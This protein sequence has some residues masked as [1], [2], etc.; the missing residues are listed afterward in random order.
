MP[1]EA[2]PIQSPQYIC[3]LQT[4][5]TTPTKEKDKSFKTRVKHT[6]TWEANKIVQKLQITVLVEDS[7]AKKNSGLKAQHGLS[8]FIQATSRKT[9]TS[10]LMDTGPSGEAL[11]N[12]VERLSV[13]LEET[14]AILLSH[15]HYDHV[16]GLIHALKRI[17]KRVPIIA[18]PNVFSVKLKTK[19]K[20]RLIG[21]SFPTSE[22]EAYSTLVYAVN[23]VT[24]AEEIVASGEIPRRTPYE[25]VEGFWTVTDN[26]FEKDLILDDQALYVK[27]E[28]KGLVVITGCAHSGIINTVKHA[29]KIMNE[30]RIHAV[31]GGF[32]LLNASED[33][34][35][36]TTEEFTALHPSYVGLCHCTGDE[37]AKAFKK[38][39]PNVCHRIGT[40]D[41]IHL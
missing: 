23:P 15:G 12:N 26:R 34:I 18:H 37:A 1:L 29:Q 32:H 39:M 30:T 10:I 33:R 3:L 27:L 20:I 38:A 21:A 36:K 5:P 35:Q 2:N 25:H 22:I 13:P 4:L 16:N 14:D 24:I 41:I 6:H 7:L 9:E 28:N 31:I 8:L 17:G 19:P 40:G 11:I